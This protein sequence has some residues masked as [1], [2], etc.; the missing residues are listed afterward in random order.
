MI[1]VSPF[2][3]DATLRSDAFVQDPY[4][5]YARLRE[6]APVCWSSAW[7]CWLLTKYEDVVG[8]LNTPARFS[9]GRRLT[10]VFESEYSKEFQSRIEPL[11]RH[12]NTGL[13]NVD[14]GDHS[15][16]R[17]LVQQ[18]FTPAAIQKM[19]EHIRS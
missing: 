10:T 2:D 6:Q 4:P 15:R 13:I 17:R 19:Q 3:I 7:G 1:D 16:L 12:Y 5:T 11:I 14:G 18:G 9:S 8:T